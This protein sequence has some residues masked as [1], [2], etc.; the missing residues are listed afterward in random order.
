MSGAP[1]HVGPSLYLSTT[2]WTS[3]GDSTG[4]VTRTPPNLKEEIRPAQPDWVRKSSDSTSLRWESLRTTPGSGV[5]A[6]HQG[7]QRLLR[8]A[9]L[10]CLVG[11]SERRRHV[12][13]ASGYEQCRRRVERNDV[14]RGAG[15]APEYAAD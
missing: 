3:P 14:V 4:I 6:A 2:R 10:D 5:G 13:G 1:L 7:L 11:Q 12:L 9:A 8:L 15:L